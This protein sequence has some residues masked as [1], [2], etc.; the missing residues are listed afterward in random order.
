MAGADQVGRAHEGADFADSVDWRP[1]Q[2]YRPS[3]NTCACGTIWESHTKWLLTAN[4]P[5]SQVPC[6][7]C[8]SHMRI[9]CSE[10][11]PEIMTVRG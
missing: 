9:R 11:Q 6:P 1:H 3:R 10:M 5:V 7:G 2:Q 8:G 4:S